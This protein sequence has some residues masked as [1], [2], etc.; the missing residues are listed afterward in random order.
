MRVIDD[1]HREA[2]GLEPA[3]PQQVG[4]VDVV[5]GTG[6]AR[7]AD[8]ILGVEL[9]LGVLA[10]HQ[11]PLGAARDDHAARLVRVLL[12]RLAADRLQLVR[13]QDHQPPPARAGMIAT[14]SPSFNGVASPCRA[15]IASLF[16]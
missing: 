14:S 6:V 13:A 16:T 7:M 5:G 1:G 10:A 9:V 15:S 2:L 11:T 4:G 8:G 12:D 3:D